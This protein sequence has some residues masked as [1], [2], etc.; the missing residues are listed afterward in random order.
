MFSKPLW[1]SYLHLLIVTCLGSRRKSALGAGKAWFAME[2]KTEHSATI[3]NSI[4]T[5]WPARGD[6]SCWLLVTLRMWLPMSCKG[7]HYP[8]FT[9]PRAFTVFISVLAAWW[10]TRQDWGLPSVG[11]SGFIQN[12]KLWKQ[13][14]CPCWSIKQDRAL[15]G[16]H[17]GLHS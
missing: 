6:G 7:C 1:N 15:R 2:T 9:S 11:W 5:W 10:L 17:V 16:L 14:L 13:S 4:A 3:L 12:C 8:S